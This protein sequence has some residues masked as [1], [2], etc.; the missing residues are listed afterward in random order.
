[1]VL[2]NDYRI[3]LYNGET[4]VC[5][6]GEDGYLRV[7]FSTETGLQMLLPTAMPAHETAFAMTVHK[8]QGSE[9]DAVWLLLP[10]TDNPVLSRELIYTGMTKAKTRL[11]LLGPEPVFRM[12]VSRMT[13]R[14]SGLGL[15]LLDV[16]PSCGPALLQ[17]TPGQTN[18]ARSTH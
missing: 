12:A 8:S 6:L 18:Y 5:L 15:K 16:Q 17:Q 13:R 3:G 7:W 11:T 2:Q 14:E 9:F 1:M 4:G 10:A